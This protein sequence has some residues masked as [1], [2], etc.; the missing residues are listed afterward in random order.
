MLLHVGEGCRVQR[1]VLPGLRGGRQPGRGG[2]GAIV[3]AEVAAGEAIATVGAAVRGEQ[4]PGPA[5][6]V[7]APIQ[8]SP[9]HP[10]RGKHATICNSDRIYGVLTT[11]PPCTARR[12]ALQGQALGKQ[13]HNNMRVP[14]NSRGI[15]RVPPE[16]RLAWRHL[17]LL[18]GDALLGESGGPGPMMGE[19]AVV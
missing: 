5:A 10:Q 18:T 12:A 2:S 7:R 8:A 14:R 11:L 15:D 16:M 9:V 3:R 1:L 19:L 6:G 13:E 17:K 4:P